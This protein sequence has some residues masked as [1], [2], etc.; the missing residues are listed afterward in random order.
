VVSVVTPQ[1]AGTRQAS[2]SQASAGHVSTGGAVAT[3][4]SAYGAKSGKSGKGARDRSGRRINDGLHWMLLR[5]IALSAN[6]S[7]VRSGQ[8]GLAVLTI[9]FP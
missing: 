8:P 4:P 5:Q 3:E 6:L 9:E 2:T 1:A 7:V